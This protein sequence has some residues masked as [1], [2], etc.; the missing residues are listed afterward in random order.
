M[1][2][3]RVFVVTG[4]PS[5][6]S[7]KSRGSICGRDHC[8]SLGSF[9]GFDCKGE[10]VWYRHILYISYYYIIYSC[11]QI[12]S[13]RFAYID[14]DRYM[15]IDRYICLCPCRAKVCIHSQYMRHAHTFVDSRQICESYLLRMWLYSVCGCA[16]YSDAMGIL[17]MSG[18]SDVDEILSCFMVLEGPVSTQDCM[19]MS[20]Y[21][22]KCDHQCERSK[23]LSMEITLRYSNIAGNGKWTPIED[24]FPIKKM[25]V[26]HGC[27][28]SLPEGTDRRCRRR[29]QCGSRIQY[30]VFF[31]VTRHGW[32]S[33]KNRL[34]HHR[35]IGWIFLFCK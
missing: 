2:P 31:D 13:H 16:S 17:S 33:W 29:S 11:L 27:Y 23:R 26:L 25:G 24:A 5:S 6:S 1:A 22:L 14:M 12:Y 15:Q 32:K 18:T 7:A 9:E 8:W 34:N 10:F 30:Q 35:A 4:N 28:V 3:L 20:F 19:C 21:H